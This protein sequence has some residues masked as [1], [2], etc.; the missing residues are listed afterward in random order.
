MVPSIGLLFDCEDVLVSLF[1]SEEDAASVG[2][3]WLETYPD[4]IAM[5]VPVEIDHCRHCGQCIQEKP[6]WVLHKWM[7]TATRAYTCWNTQLTRAEPKE[8]T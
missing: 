4:G 8:S 1:D 2:A 5:V 7:H 3:Y 6:G